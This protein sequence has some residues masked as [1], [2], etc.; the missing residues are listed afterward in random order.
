MKIK[1]LDFPIIYRDDNATAY[2]GN[3]DWFHESWQKRAGCASTSGANLAAYYAQKNPLMKNFYAGDSKH[4][5]QMEYLKLMEEMYRYM[6]PG[7][8][9]FPYV[10]KFAKQFIRFCKDH[11]ETMQASIL[12]DFDTEI[13]AF[14]FVKE[15]IDKDRPIALLILFHRAGEI[16]ENTWH[17]VTITGYEEELNS[18]NSSKVI[19]S[20]YGKLETMDAKVLFEVHPKN[21][22]RMVSFH[23]V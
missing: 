2:G 7:P 8:M 15:N 6:K 22:L 19:I 3:Q 20:N 21:T 12:S 11:G 16:R 1:E 13:E 17:W 5:N 4:L 23:R 9:G 10:K 14:H 18:H